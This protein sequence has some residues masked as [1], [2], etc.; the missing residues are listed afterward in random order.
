VCVGVA[1]GAE[2]GL[3]SD[4]KGARR[5]V[6]LQV[7]DANMYAALI[8]DTAKGGSKG[9]VLAGVGDGNGSQAAIDAL[10]NAVKHGVVVVRVSRPAQASSTATWRPTMTSSSAGRGRAPRAIRMLNRTR[11]PVCRRATRSRIK[12]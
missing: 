1:G 2:S 12:G 7:G 4:E 11:R 9:I 10:A 3:R 8:N 6:L 5:I